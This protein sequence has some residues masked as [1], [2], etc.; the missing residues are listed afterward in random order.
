MKKQV[1][2]CVLALGTSAPLLAD[3]CV[4][5]T[6][7][8]C[9]Q[10]DCKVSA[11]TFFTVRPQFQGVMPERQTFMREA[12]WAKEDGHH[13]AF[14]LTF[15]GGQSRDAGRIA[16]YFGPSCNNQWTVEENVLGQSDIKADYFNI[17]T[18]TGT[19]KS[20]IS[21]APQQSVFGIGLHYK[22]AFKR[23]CDEKGCFIEISMP[24]EHVKNTMGFTE[25]IID[26]G[27]GAAVQGGIE[28]MAEAFSQPAFHYGRIYPSGNSA[29]ATDNTPFIND[30]ENES[31]GCTLE[32]WGVADID[33]RL[34]W[35]CVRKETVTLDSFVGVLCPTGNKPTAHNVFE[36]IVGHNK[37]FG[38]SFGSYTGIEVW[39]HECK[40]R[41]VWA[42]ANFFGLYLF[43]NTQ[44]RLIDVYNK[45]WSHYMYV[46][47][48]KAAATRAVLS[49]DVDANTPGVNVFAQNVCVKPGF[50]LQA[51]TALVYWASN[52]D[53]EVGCN[54]FAREAECV[55]LACC[56][57]EGPAFKSPRTVDGI[58]GFTDDVETI[59]N[60][61]NYNNTVPLAEY[62]SNIIK[63]GDLDLNSAAHPA[64]LT[65]TVYGA[66]G[67]RWEK[68]DYPHFVGIGGSWEFAPDNTGLDR[69]LLW[70]KAGVS[71]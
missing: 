3:C 53:A 43:Q 17:Q 60:F 30:C 4:P 33:I 41:R 68:C 19:F 11:K 67:H 48:N 49:G 46:Y 9:S 29:I 45:P 62:E 7:G 22:H 1:V 5:D 23:D 42:S 63:E 57:K 36:P 26:N 38:L 52:F 54:F 59:G 39:H 65:Y 12:M 24:I 13:G 6:T 50:Q 44:T 55:K 35:E 25:D 66:L 21:F 10:C 32:K 31:I 37:H 71:F 56:W 40:D 64:V 8:A 28:S 70:A 61:Y 58:A 2:L 51:N 47:A 14:S 15:Y 34:G 69:W 18:K 20:V 16:A 27:A